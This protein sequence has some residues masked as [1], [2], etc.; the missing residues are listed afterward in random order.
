M[1]MTDDE[2]TVYC[3]I[4]NALGA[5]QRASAVGEH[6]QGVESLPDPR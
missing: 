4:Q 1:G 3:D 2:D 5:G 6:T